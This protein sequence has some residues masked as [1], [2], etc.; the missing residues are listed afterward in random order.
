MY[1]ALSP[2]AV[3]C[4]PANLKDAIDLARGHGFGGVELS[5]REVINVD[6]EHGAGTAKRWFDAAG[7]VPAGFGLPVDWRGEEAKWREGLDTLP[8]LARAAAGLGCRRCMTWVMP[9]SD[10]RDYDV[11]R[12][13]HVER[14]APAARIL[15]EH[16]IA[17]GLEFIGPKTLRDARKYPFIYTMGDMLELGREIGP[18]VGLLLD[19]WHWYTSGATVAQLRALRPEQVV[20]VHVSDAPA[21]I[22]VDEQ[23][24][25][26]RALPG[27]TGVIDIAAFLRSLD[28]IGYDGPITAEPF[29]AELKELPSDDARLDVVS[30][31]LDVIFQKAG[32][33]PHTPGVR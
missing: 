25:N 31:A 22:P 2:G 23:I 4:K 10:E 18:N 27:E 20:Y 9:S 30:K 12:R 7:L 26:R 13:F 3:N 16:G 6:A 19:V 11:N 21:G 5:P 15:G 32:L 29:K 33:T 1:K 24:D 28:A 8:E 17:L 14:F